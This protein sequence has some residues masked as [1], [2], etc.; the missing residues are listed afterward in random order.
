[1]KLRAFRTTAPEILAL[2]RQKK[3]VEA[4]AEGAGK[5]GTAAEQRSWQASL[6]ALAKLL[7]KANLRG[8]TMLVEC[9]VPGANKR[10]DV[11]LAG[12]DPATSADRYVVV[13]LKQWTDAHLGWDS[14]L[15][16]WTLLT[17][18]DQLHPVDQVRGYCRYLQ[19]DV[20]VLHESPNALH[21]AAFL[22]NAEVSDVEP[23][24]L[25]K[26]DQF[27]RLFT[28]DQTDQFT[29]FL[30]ERLAQASGD[31]GA[32][33]RLLESEIYRRKT[34]LGFSTGDLATT[35]DTLVDN[36]RLAFEAVL[37]RISHAHGSRQKTVVL[38][39]GGPG[40]GKSL[41]ALSLL[42]RLRAD[43]RKVRYATGSEAITKT[44]RRIYGR[45]DRDLEEQITYYKNLA[46]MKG[47]WLDVVICDEAHRIRRTSTD[48]WTAGSQRSKR[49]QIDEL[50]DA[51]KVPVFL[52]D[53][54][55]VVRPDEVGTI[56]HIREH[57]A[58]AGLPVFQ[59]NL[60][61]QF[62]CGGSAAY[63]E[64]VLNLLGLRA[65][66]PMPWK[67][68]GKFTVRVAHLPQQMEDFL[69]AKITPAVTARITAGYCWDWTPEP[70]SA[71]ALVEDIQI[72]DWSKPWNK[73]DP[74]IG[75][76]HEPPPSWLWAHDPRGFDQVGCIYT[77]QGFE[78]NWAGVIL[79]PEIGV[80]DGRLVV[81]RD[82]N[83][84]KALKSKR[85]FDEDFDILI[86][87]TYKVLLTRGMQGV[88]I[89]AV[90]PATQ[91]FISGLVESL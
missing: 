79:G 40:S 82:A 24:F 54:N 58:R 55:Q 46:K 38:V 66:G 62:R 71:G 51:A 47:E 34:L 90:D 67:D 15:I 1:M 16:V 5:K 83:K 44:M 87:N 56:D 18:G 19:R 65:F 72:G 20:A 7:V 89:Y 61:G 22:H 52:L 86:R 8:V 29:D 4:V 36:Q 12:T 59:I 31:G 75:K 42:E 28:G 63:D 2:A 30:Q 57:A 50:I 48:R 43:H 37:S 17:R 6:P 21:G 9:S 68:D 69:R 60:D 33:T 76:A 49:P 27:G 53:E 41:I 10:I 25:L 73:Y 45:Q 84:D 70:D 11:I 74:K 3:L 39:S 26:P 77:A 81:R 23:L 80:E 32:A 85:L 35:A 14:E 78:F 13:E 91:E 64:W 88:V